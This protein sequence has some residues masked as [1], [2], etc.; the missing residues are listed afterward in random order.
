MENV[1]EVDEELGVE[2]LTWMF[3]QVS[4][5]FIREIG[6]RFLASGKRNEEKRKERELLASEGGKLGRRDKWLRN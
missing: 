4:D 6:E 5:S 1:L 3:G 2:M